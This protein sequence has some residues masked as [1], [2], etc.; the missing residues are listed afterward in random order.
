MISIHEAIYAFNST[1][2]HIRG[3]VAYDKD[4]NIVEYD[5]AQVE[6]KLAEMQAEELAKQEAKVIAKA[7][8]S[9]KLIA[10]GLTPDEVKAL[11]G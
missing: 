6:A 4:E 8:A 11:L 9:T 2:T 5:I 7:S 3:N 10:L 1:I